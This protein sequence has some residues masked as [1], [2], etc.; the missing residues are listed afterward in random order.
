MLPDAMTTLF[1]IRH[2]LTAVTGSRLY[3][4]T[5]GIHL[6]ERGRRQA[7]ALVERFDGVRLSAIY[8]SP[9]ER[10]LETLE[11]LA[12]ARGLE[13]RTSDALVEMDAGDWT[14]RTLLSLRRTK[15]WGTVQRNP[16][17]FHFPAGEG[18]LEAEARILDEIERIVARHPRGRV[19]IG[20]HGDLVRMLISH[21]TGAHLDQFQRVLADPASVSV[22]HLGRRR[23]SDPARERHGEPPSLRAGATTSGGR[24][25]GGNSRGNRRGSCEDRSMDL[26]PVDR[27]TTD[28]IGE[29]GARVFY[30]QARAGVELVTVI[31]EKQQVQLLAASV[32]EL[33]E[34]VPG[35]E[36]GEAEPATG[37][38]ASEG[39]AMALEDP[40]DPRWRAG[41]LSIG[42]DQDRD[43]FLLEVEEFQPDLEDLDED[44]PRS[45]AAGARYRS[46]NRSA[47]GRRRR[48]CWRSRDTERTSPHE[49][50][51]RASSAATRS[52]R[53]ATRVPR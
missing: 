44:D 51:R 11:P 35:S 53:R 1:L 20:T 23:P 31:V 38:P 36:L 14:G 27:I 18:F 4:R 39:S 28:A 46:R 52:T 19:L 6:D 47:S 42:F 45:I 17:R 30:I 15:L 10:C 5:A 32:L 48:R 2:G 25:A 7:A 37:E 33:L 49:A 34:D 41:R 21:Y 26:G 12:E 3:G 8:S 9:L 22:V 50:G 24:P 16:S 13:I 29:P 40:I 43:L